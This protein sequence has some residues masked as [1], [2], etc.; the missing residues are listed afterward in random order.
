MVIKVISTVL[1]NNCFIL[2]ILLAT[3]MIDI[4]MV[5][6]I[7]ELVS[8]EEINRL[9]VRQVKVILKRNCIDYK[10]CVE[11]DE[12]LEKVK[13]LWRAKEEE[14]SKLPFYCTTANL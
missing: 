12:L 1:I 2:L 6:T 3:Q 10:G 5:T 11:K 9:S 8:E 13:L 4:T 7:E 14:K